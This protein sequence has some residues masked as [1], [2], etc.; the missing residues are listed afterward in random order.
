[1]T[2]NDI[3]EQPKPET[4]VPQPVQKPVVVLTPEQVKQPT[5]EV[6]NVVSLVEKTVDVKE[7]KEIR[8]IKSTL[9]TS[10]E[11]TT[12]TPQGVQTVVVVS[13]NANPKDVTLIDVKSEVP[14]KPEAP[15]QPT[16]QAPVPSYTSVIVDSTN[17]KD[18]TTNEKT[19]ITSSQWLKLV[20]EEAARK[21]PSLSGQTITCFSEDAFKNAIQVTYL[22]SVNSRVVLVSGFVW[23]SD[24]R[25]E[26]IEVPQSGD[27]GLAESR[28][29]SCT[30]RSSSITTLTKETVQTL[31]TSDEDIKSLV[32]YVTSEY[33]P[34]S[35]DKVV[36]EKFASSI[37]YVILVTINKVTQRVVLVFTRLTKKFTVIEKPDVIKATKPVVLETKVEPDGSKVVTSNSVEQVKTVDEKVE[38]FLTT[39]NQQ[40]PVKVSE[41]SNI[42][43]KQSVNTN[44]YTITTKTDKTTNEIKAVLKKDDDSVIVTEVKQQPKPLI[45]PFVRPKVEVPKEKYTEPKIQRV[46]EEINNNK[47]IPNIR[48]EDITE[49][50]QTK[51]PTSTSYEV[52]T[53]SP[54]GKQTFIV[55]ETS[56]G[57]VTVIDYKPE[58]KPSQPIEKQPV[59]TE[60][61]INPVSGIETKTTNDAAVIKDSKPV[62]SV[63]TKLVEQKTITK[64]TEVVSAVTKTSGSTVT[65]TVVLRSPEKPEENKVVVAVV[66][67]KNDKVTI[68]ADKKVEVVD[69]NEPV[70]VDDEVVQ[71][72]YTTT[73][74]QKTIKEDK[75]LRNIIE[76]VSQI[77]KDV[78]DVTPTQVTM[79]KVGDKVLSTVS[80]E[81]KKVTTVVYD[82]KTEETK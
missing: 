74:I 17:V 66:D 26:I 22:A 21:Q 27:N 23:T 55:T 13:D 2:V 73:V 61:T 69:Q 28:Y 10:Y 81:G 77:N 36:V 31:S 52:V 57:E 35:I 80:Y 48:T 46:V 44:E 79:D 15:S 16:T 60:Y 67:R 62:Q 56:K 33:Q 7:V 65:T 25:I 82:E 75:T 71:T 37:K 3:Q 1:M 53:D 64:N 76:K 8:E 70:S 4:V 19:L 34:D 11:V 30:E 41:I 45:A 20:S 5:P 68:V 18:T 39:L 38:K 43:S 42:V 32:S 63:V 9:T 6:R 51:T 47:K 49:V 54:K 72:V 12:Q 50:K 29:S 78:K 14:V 40:V 24:S 58:T 59:K